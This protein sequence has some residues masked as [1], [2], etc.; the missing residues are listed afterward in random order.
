MYNSEFI[1]VIEEAQQEV[2]SGNILEGDLD[3]LVK[4]IDE[5]DD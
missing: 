5:C 2:R 1:K 3:E 4:K